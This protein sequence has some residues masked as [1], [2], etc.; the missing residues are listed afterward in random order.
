MAHSASSRHCSETPAIEVE[1]DGRRTRPAPL[2][3]TRTRPSGA[4]AKGRLV[5]KNGAHPPLTDPR[6]FGILERG[7]GSLGVG[8]HSID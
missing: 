3:L 8:C 4:L 1:A 6:Q 5:C 7:P 2:S